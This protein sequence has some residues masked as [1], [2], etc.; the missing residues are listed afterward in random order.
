[1]KYL[2][3]ILI[4]IVVITG[5]VL[6]SSNGG[7]LGGVGS[8]GPLVRATATSTTMLAKTAVTVLATSTE[9]VYRS[10][11]NG[12]LTGMFC[13]VGETAVWQKGIF[14]RPS[15]TMSFCY[16]AGDSGCDVPTIGTVSCISDVNATG[17]VIV[18]R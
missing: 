3:I 12:N 6:M 16:F 1:M 9:G 4:G 10:I 15:S 7:N 8:S 5:V 14:V 11:G 2:I 17:S 13:S 18:G